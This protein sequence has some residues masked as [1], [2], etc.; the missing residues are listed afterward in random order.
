MAEPIIHGRQFAVA[1][2]CRKVLNKY[3][4]LLGY[5]YSTTNTLRVPDG[6]VVGIVCAIP[7]VVEYEDG[8]SSAA[9]KPSDGE[10]RVDLPHPAHPR[11]AP[12]STVRFRVR[13][14]PTIN[15]LACFCPWRP[16]EYAESAPIYFEYAAP[17]PAGGAP[18]PGDPAAQ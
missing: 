15:H 4:V 2:E 8:L 5:K 11:L 6:Q 9:S 17:T 16:T 13:T 18:S 10:H 3:S 7:F 14:Q 12:T 1:L